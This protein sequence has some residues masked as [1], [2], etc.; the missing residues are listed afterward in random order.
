[1]KVQNLI[2]P[3]SVYTDLYFLSKGG[4]KSELF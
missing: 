1:M 2:Q 3:K 4:N